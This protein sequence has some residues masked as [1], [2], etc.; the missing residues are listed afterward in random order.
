MAE[1]SD[2]TADAPSDAP[3]RRS[4]RSYVRR[5]GRITEAQ[6]QALA[7]WSERFCIGP[8]TEPLD[9]SAMLRRKLCSHARVFLATDWEDYADHIVQVMDLSL[10]HISEPTRP[11]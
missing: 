4:I 2:R 8:G 1:G 10:I 7:T 11:Y 6:Q 5:E 3:P 9:L